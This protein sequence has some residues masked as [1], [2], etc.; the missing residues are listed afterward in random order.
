M[1][2]ETIPASQ[3]P[4]ALLN[5]LQRS[6]PAWD[7]IAERLLDAKRG[8]WLRVRLA[9][10]PGKQNKH[11]QRNVANAMEQR[12]LLIRTRIL[13][14]HIWFQ[15]REPRKPKQVTSGGAAQR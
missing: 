12:K 3:A 8:D 2:I 11:K 13:G 15:V 7:M 14:D 9:E 4:D 6:N 1:N 5:F 10:M